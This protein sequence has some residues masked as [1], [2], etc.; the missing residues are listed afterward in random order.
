MEEQDS[1]REMIEGCLRKDRRAQKRLYDQY[2]SKLFAVCLSYSFDYEEAQDNLH[3]G[4]IKILMYMN[5]YKGEGSF[6]GW[7][8]RIMVN[9]SLERY[10]RRHKMKLIAE[11]I[12]AES[13]LSVE[14]IL[15]EISAAE[16]M[17]AVQELSPQYRM[18]FLLY[19]V[20]GY[21]HKEI[22][23]MLEIS[24][25]TSKSNYSRARSVLQERLKNYGTPAEARGRFRTIKPAAEDEIGVK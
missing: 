8:R 2:A 25:G 1:I 7:M 20:E 9:T 10:R 13:S 23:K 12:R 15:E 22:G 5:Q 24:E 18:V 6:E 17:D 11:E 21:N 19:A 14:H 16:L 4:F 3:D